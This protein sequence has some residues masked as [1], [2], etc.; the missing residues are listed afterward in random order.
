M[1]F[2]LSAA[3][4]LCSL[5]PSQT[6]TFLSRRSVISSSPLSAHVTSVIPEPR[7][8]LGDVDDFLP[9]VPRREQ[10]VEP[11]DAE[12]RL[13]AEHHLLRDDVGATGTDRDVEV[14]VVVE[15]LVEGRV[16]ARELRLHHPLG[17]Q[18]HLVLVTVA[19]SVVAAARRQ[20][21]ERHGEKRG[22]HQPPA[23]PHPLP[24]SVPI[25]ALSYSAAPRADGCQRI[26]SRSSAA[27]A[28]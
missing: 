24:L 13:A 17:L 16:V 21:E 9:L 27:T 8:D 23:L 11:V 28:A 14:L 12:L 22:E 6:P 10:A 20:R 3:K 15:A 5:P 2:L 18:G 1:P 25:T 7:E 19:A 26:V 4:S